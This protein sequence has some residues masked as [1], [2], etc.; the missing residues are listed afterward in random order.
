MDC[1][2][3]HSALGLIAGLGDIWSIRH[4]PQ[5]ISYNGSLRLM[6]AI[7]ILPGCA[8][9]APYVGRSRFPPRILTEIDF[10]PFVMCPLD[11][12]LHRGVWIC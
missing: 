12:P 2:P 7:S 1:I 6:P 8:A 4:G 11:D 10:A 9:L 5:L 3:G